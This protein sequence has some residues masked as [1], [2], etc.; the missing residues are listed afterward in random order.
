MHSDSFVMMAFI[1]AFSLYLPKFSIWSIGLG[2]IR[3]EDFIAGISFLLLILS[4]LY[5]NT[6]HYYESLKNIMF[7]IVGIT[8]ISFLSLFINS[9]YQ[10]TSIGWIF[11]NVRLLEYSVFLFWG[12]VLGRKSLPI[13]LVYIILTACAVFWQKWSGVTRPTGYTS[14][15]WEAALLFNFGFILLK[16]SET[17]KIL[18]VLI[19]ILLI[20]GIVIVE[21]RIGLFASIIIIPILLKN[22]I[23][24]VFD[25]YLVFVFLFAGLIIIGISMIEKSERGKGI[26]QLEKNIAFIGSAPQIAFG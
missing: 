16:F 11:N 17:N 20:A 12:F 21:S 13:V 10:E 25:R 1:V 5:S 23:K 4:F 6:I 24:H 19:G 3:M 15:P 14:G 8:I 18:K 22:K 7:P 9:L 26:L 2:Q